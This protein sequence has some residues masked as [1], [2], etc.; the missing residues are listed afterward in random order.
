MN[1]T[2]GKI[3]LVDD[4]ISNLDQGRKILKPFYE[5]YPAPSASKLFEILENILPDLILLDIE[6]PETNGY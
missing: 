6:M 2:R 5:V 1:N 4:N 3:I